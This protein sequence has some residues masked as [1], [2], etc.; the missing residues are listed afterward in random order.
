M[1]LQ[2]KFR[3]IL[4]R[5]AHEFLASIDEKTRRKI[6]QTFDRASL[7]LDPEVFKTWP[8]RI[9]GSFVQFLGKR[10]IVYL[11]SGI[12]QNKQTPW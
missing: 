11:R 2:P 3:V 8:I 6:Y 10:N 1:K 4:Y 7:L 5:E 12:R 9:Y